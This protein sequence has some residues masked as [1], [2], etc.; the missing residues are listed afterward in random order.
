MADYL[1]AAVLTKELGMGLENNPS[2]SSSTNRS[3]PKKIIHGT[4]SK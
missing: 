3:G 4:N 2:I 1:G